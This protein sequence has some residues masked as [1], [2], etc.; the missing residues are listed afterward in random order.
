[1][2]ILNNREIAI[3]FW[4]II[5][6]SYIGFAKNMKDVRSAFG[7]I[8]SILLGRPLVVV[9]LLML[10]YTAL[11]TYLLSECGLWRVDQLKNTIFWF[12]SVGVPTIY[13]LEKTKGDKNFYKDS[14]VG[15]MKLLAVL[16]F[17][18]GVYNFPLLAEL[19]LIPIMV[20]VGCMIPLA[21]KDPD[22]Q[23]VRKL[24]NGIVVAF[25]LF[26]VAYTA[27]MLITDLK[28]ITQEKTFYDF[29]VPALLTILYVPFVFAMM[30]YS[31]YE[32]AFVRL[33]FMMQDSG[34][35][36][37]AKLYA[38]VL[39]NFKLG[40]LKRWSDHI[41]RVEINSHKQLLSTFSHL[42]KLRKLEESKA[43]VPETQGWSPY[44]AKEFL[45]SEG[46]STRHYNL[47][48]ADQWSASSE[49]YEIGSGLLSDNIAYYVEGVEGVA[50]VLKIKLNVNDARHG[51][52]TNERLLVL[53]AVLIRKSIG[54][55][56]S[57]S[58]KHAIKIGSSHRER[59]GDK[60]IV[61][62]KDSWEGHRLGGYDVKVEV[63]AI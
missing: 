41:A 58:V 21:E 3:T 44:L 40:L 8:V 61:V 20:M 56:I 62:Q 4:V 7:N 34:L 45:L 30:V 31:S 43:E 50:K 63:I 18:V 54:I 38:L 2:E 52:Q 57:D 28:E 13:N 14:V 29:F 17:V 25:G 35:R 53:S 24:L 12:F 9:F 5:V 39:I 15:S 11:M 33:Q 1:M 10:A 48:Y 27:Y 19:F 59:H 42:R 32:T 16:Q 55:D 26:T 22:H 36:R 23:P 49:M 6:A 51:M 37:L 60:E 46:I 47:Q